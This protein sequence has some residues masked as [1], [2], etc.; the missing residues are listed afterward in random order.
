MSVINYRINFLQ[1]VDN[2]IINIRSIILQQRRIIRLQGVNVSGSVS[3]DKNKII[4][5]KIKLL[6]MLVSGRKKAITAQM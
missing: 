2:F 6:K 3:K 4:W 5:T 1:V